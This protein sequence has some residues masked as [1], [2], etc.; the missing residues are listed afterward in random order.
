MLWDARHQLD[1]FHSDSTGMLSDMPTFCLH[2]GPIYPWDLW[3]P[4]VFGSIHWS[5]QLLDGHRN[6]R[7]T[8][9]RSMGAS[10]ADGK[11][12]RSQ[13]HIFYG[14]NVRIIPLLH[15]LLS[16]QR[17]ANFLMIATGFAS[18]PWSGSK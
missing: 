2:L 4:E 3:R 5:V 14:Y 17:I 13:R 6:C 15:R 11:E 7:I 16:V 8:I 1:L 9:A 10:N 18:S 12:S